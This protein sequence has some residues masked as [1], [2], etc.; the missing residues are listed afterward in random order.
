M[1]TAPPS[2]TIYSVSRL[3]RAAKLLLAEHF[4][5][6][7]V[8]GE[9]SNLATPTSGHLYFTLKDADAQVRCA[10]FRQQARYLCFRPENGMQVL[11][12]AQVSLYEPRGDYQLVVESLEQAGDGALQRAFEALKKKLAA[13]GLFDAT[14][15][16]PIPRLPNRI[17]VITS[18][19]GAAVRDIVTVLKRRFPA[20]AVT[21]LPVKVQGTEAKFEIVKA[22]Q[23]ADRSGLCD[24]L[25]LARGGGSLEDLWAFNEE[26]V[27]RAIYACETPVIT[28]VGH[29]IDFTIADFVADLRAPTPSA[30]AEAASP[31]GEAWLAGLQRLESRLSQRALALLRQKTTALNHA[32]KRL[33]QQHPA[34]R[35]QNQAQ[36]LDELE[37]RLR[38]AATGDLQ[39][40]RQRLERGQARL[41]RHDPRQHLAVLLTHASHLQQRLKAAMARA[42]QPRQQELARLSHALQTISPLATLGRGYAIAFRQRDREI[43]RSFR[44]I[45]PGERLETRLAEG[46][47]ISTVED[48]RDA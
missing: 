17:G 8:E 2:R 19:T 37:A 18:P 38:R 3:N 23:A 20:I 28:G 27:A 14:R 33:A 32:E 12:R 13:E 25:I 39:R 35:L 36:R 7:W 9:L 41:Q 48:T 11:A 29:E 15:K 43:I 24:V 21:I 46:I 1:S 4:D 31:D 22:I 26:A 16:R 40:R 5:V 47:V 44:D 45:A 42:L 10:L 30:A 34:K 6:V